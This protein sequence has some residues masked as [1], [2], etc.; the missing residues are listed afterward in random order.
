MTNGLPEQLAVTIAYLDANAIIRF[1]EA[2]DDLFESILHR[3]RGGTL[4]LCTSEFTLAEVLVLPLRELNDEL[5]AVYETLLSTDGELEIVPLSRAVLRKSAELR[6]GSRSK[7]PDAIHVAT[8]VLSDC[9]VFVS[10][11]QRL[12]LPPTIRR[13][14]ADRVRGP[15]N[16]D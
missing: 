12:H 16:W 14:D 6:A 10:S 15:E 9:T 2:D 8:A 11:D 3:V 1:V 13:I 4:R 7:A 5:A